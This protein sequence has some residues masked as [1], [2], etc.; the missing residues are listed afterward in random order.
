MP[1]IPGFYPMA[2][3]TNSFDSVSM[4]IA[5]TPQIKMYLEDLTL[6]GTY[7]SSP[8]EAARLLISQAIEAKIKDG[9]LTR[10]KFMIQDGDVVALPLPA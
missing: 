10:R 5:V 3:P 4:T 9:L 2:R 1:L 7:G 8:A 6:D